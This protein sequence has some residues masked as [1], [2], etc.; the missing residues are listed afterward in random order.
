MKKCKGCNIKKDLSEF[1]TDKQKI[2][3]GLAVNCKLC[4]STKNKAEYD[5]KKPNKKHRQIKE[6]SGNL[7]GCLYKIGTNLVTNVYAYPTNRR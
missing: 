6:K 1:N 7:R 3:D 4:K 2:K 5:A